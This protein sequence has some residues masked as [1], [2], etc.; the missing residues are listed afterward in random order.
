MIDVINEGK[1][2]SVHAKV[3]ALN[4]VETYVRGSQR[5]DNV[6]A[7]ERVAECVEY[8]NIAPYNEGIATDQRALVVDIHTKDLRRRPH[9][10]GK[11]R[12]DYKT[13]NKMTETGN[14]I[15]VI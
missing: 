11:K 13:R 12:E 15:K 3:D 4:E 7:K 8:M 1:L 2:V 6:F 14:G 5:I 9:K 10:L